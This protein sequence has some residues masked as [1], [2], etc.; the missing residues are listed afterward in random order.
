VSGL[1]FVSAIASIVAALAGDA[2]PIPA[3][4]RVPGLLAAGVALLVSI[5]ASFVSFLAPPHKIDRDFVWL[6]KVDSGYLAQFPP[7]A[8]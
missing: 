5:R 2:L 7:F 1:S 3:Y 4:L 8:G 6:K